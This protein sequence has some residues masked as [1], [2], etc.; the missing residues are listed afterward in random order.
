M[1][2]EDAKPT[3]SSKHRGVLA[4]GVVLHL[5]NAQPHAEAVTIGTIQKLKSELLHHPVYSPDLTHLITIFLDHSKMCH[6]DANLQ[7]TE[8]SQ[9]QCICGFTCN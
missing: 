4:N 8:R 1:L 7:M 9:M 3:I 6:V 5:D 2:E